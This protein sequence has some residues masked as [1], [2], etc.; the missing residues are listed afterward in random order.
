MKINK[1]KQTKKDSGTQHLSSR[2]YFD[3]KYTSIDHLKD[4]VLLDSYKGS[5]IK[6]DDPLSYN[7]QTKIGLN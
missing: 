1:N 2:C 7:P 3:W 5:L 6:F 4:G